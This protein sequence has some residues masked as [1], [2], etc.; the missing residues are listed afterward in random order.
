ML[1]NTNAARDL[2][3]EIQTIQVRCTPQYVRCDRLHISNKSD[4]PSNGA[5]SRPRATEPMFGRSLQSQ[6]SIVILGEALLQPNT[7][8]L[9]R[10][11][12]S[13]TG[14]ERVS[15]CMQPINQSTLCAR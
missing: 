10:Q 7:S 9:I 5:I 8:H 1:I 4:I 12:N 11:I 3:L 14:M 15:E 13:A 2:A 6:L